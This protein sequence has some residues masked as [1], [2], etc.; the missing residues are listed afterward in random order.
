MGMRRIAGIRSINLCL[1][2]IGNLYELNLILGKA[3]LV[4]ESETSLEGNWMFR[5]H[6]EL[7]IFGKG[8]NFFEEL[9]CLDKDVD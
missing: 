1:P 7:V 4:P 9:S 3:T 5:N 6:E 8:W 2:N